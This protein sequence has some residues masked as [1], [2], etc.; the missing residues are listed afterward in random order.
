MPR[1][2]DQGS[3]GGNEHVAQRLDECLVARLQP[4]GGLDDVPLVPRERGRRL[5]PPGRD[6]AQ[7]DVVAATGGRDRHALADDRHQRASDDGSTIP[8]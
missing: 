8:S 6:D 3:D 2:G 1:K 7:P 4:F 5:G